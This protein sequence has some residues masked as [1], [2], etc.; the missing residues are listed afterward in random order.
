MPIES[1]EMRRRPARR[2]PAIRG[3]TARQVVSSRTRLLP[4]EQ[5]RLAPL[6][7]LRPGMV[8]RLLRQQD[9]PPAEGGEPS[10]GTR[11][12]TN[13]SATIARLP[14]HAWSAASSA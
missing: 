13:L 1:Y 7:L 10:A 4:A 5:M 12:T 8:S 14:P 6:P 9:T 11:T 2:R 3:R